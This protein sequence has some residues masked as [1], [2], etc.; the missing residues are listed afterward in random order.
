MPHTGAAGFG[1]VARAVA[2]SSQ[3]LL[4][5]IHGAGAKQGREAS[6]QSGVGVG[7]MRCSSSKKLHGLGVHAQARRKRISLPFSA[8]VVSS[9]LSPPRW[10][11]GSWDADSHWLCL[12]GL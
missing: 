6:P 3:E 4:F 10:E 12:C 9:F 8:A 7:C 1:R 2:K 11:E 5:R